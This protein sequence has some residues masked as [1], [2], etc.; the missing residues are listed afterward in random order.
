MVAEF[1]HLHVHSEYS[2]LDGAG[3]IKDLVKRACEL[4]MPAIALTDHGVMY[5]IVEFYEA[6]TEAGIKPIL[7]AEIYYT[8]KSRFDR[9]SRQHAEAHHLLLLCENEVGYH[10][11]IKIVSKAHLEGFYYKPRADKELLAEYHKGL[12]AAS[13]C[14]ASPIC[15][16][17]LRDDIAAAE[18][19]ACEFREIFGPDNF[20]LELQDHG[21]PEQKKV[22]EALIAMSKK[23]GIPLIVTNDIHYVRAEDW[24]AQDVLLAINTGAKSVEEEDRFRF[25]SHEFYLKSADEMKAIFPD[26][27]DALRR[28]VEIAERCN[29]QLQLGEPKMPHYEVPGGLTPEEFLRK[30]CYERLPLR[31]P[32]ASDEVK[33]RLEY[34]LEVICQKG[35]A[36]YFLIVWDIVHYAKSQGILVG[37]GRGSAAGCMVSYILG[38]TNIDPLKYGL[39]FERFL[40]PERQSSPDIDLD[41]PDNRRDE[42]IAYVRRKY[43]ED[44]VA[45]IVTFGTLQAR[46]AVRD[47]GRVLKIDPALVDR[48]AKLIPM[49][50]SLEEALEYSLE[51]R[52]L[53][54][55]D[56]QVRRW[57]D[58][59][60]AIEGLAR[61]AS[62]HPCGVVIGSKPLIELVPLQRGHDGGII[63]QYDGPSAEKVGLVKMDFLGLRNSTIIGRTVELVKETDG[64][65]IDLN[66]L[67]LDDPKTYAMLSEGH[68]VGVFQ[69]EKSG[70][71][72]LLRDLRPDKFE[73]LV[74]LV[75]L[76]RPGPMEDIPKFVDGRHGKPIEYLHP[77][78][79]PILKETFGVML[80]QEQVMRIAHE[81]AGF[82]MPQAEIL[83]RAMAKKKA[84]LMEKMKPLFI[85]GC[86]R[87]GISE[88]DAKRIFERMEAFANYAFN[89]CV[90]A[91]TE[92]VD[93]DTG[94]VV[95]VGELYRQQRSIGVVTLGDNWQ[96]KRGQVVAVFSNGVRPVYE[97]VTQ[98]NRRIKATTNH[99]FL[100]PEGWKF[101][102]EL[103]P[104]DLVAI[105]RRI[106][107]RPSLQWC[108]HHLVVLGYLLSD[109]NLCHPTSVYFY[110][111]EPEVRD[112]FVRALERF[113]NTQARCSFIA[114]Q[115]KWEVYAKRLNRNQL[116]GVVEW[117]TQL[118]I[119]GHKATEKRLPK[120]VFRLP[121]EQI[122]LLLAKMWVGDGC[123]VPKQWIA[124]YSTSS[125]QLAR[126]VQHLLL[127]LGIVATVY[128]KRFRY[129]DEFRKGWAVYI[130]GIENLTKF[131]QILGRYFVGNILKATKELLAKIQ[132]ARGGG[133]T[134][135]EVPYHAVVPLMKASAMQAGLTLKQV[136]EK[137][138]INVRTLHYSSKKKWWRRDT[139]A[140]IAEALN[141]E[142][143]SVWGNSDLFW[144]KVVSVRF[145]GMEEVFDLTV[146]E[147]HNFVA[148]DF[149]VHNSHSAAYALVAYQTAYLKAN[150]PVQ[151]MA[152]FLSANRAFREKVI[153]GIEEC[154]RMKIPIL[155]PDI[156]LSS[157][158]FTIEEHNGQRAIRFGLGAIKNVGDNAV[159]AILQARKQGGPFKDI[160][161][162]LRRVRPYRTVTR[163]VVES[164]IKVGAFDSLHPNRNQL[165]QALETLWEQAGKSAQPAVGQVTLFGSEETVESTATL[166]L[167]DVP[168]VSFREKLEWE[169]ELLGVFL[170]ANPLQ[171]GYQVIASRITHGLDELPEITP[172][173]FVRVW[174]MVVHLKPTVDR[175]NRPL[176]FAK[177]QDH[178]GTEAELVLSGE[179]YHAFAHLFERDALVYVEGTVRVDEVYRHNGN[180]REYDEEDEEPQFVVRIVPRLVERFNLD[181]I[182]KVSRP[183][184][185]VGQMSSQLQPP[186]RHSSE[187]LNKLTQSNAVVITDQVKPTKL[188]LLLPSRL[189]ETVAQRLKELLSTHPGD[190]IVEVVIQ[191]G[192]TVKTRQLS[193]K[194]KLS[195]EFYQQLISLLGRNA[196]RVVR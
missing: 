61:H 16:A 17:I 11:L 73:H 154:R 96:L 70:W 89:K 53:Y 14:L 180:G 153:V 193:T 76:Y 4:E 185:G 131:C 116:S 174:G 179:S 86:V 106:P 24:Q 69:M 129:R 137:S 147:T 38:I 46:A 110:T 102:G 77:R 122:A 188:Q 146:D 78:L 6:C 84:D 168:D 88:E 20:F 149:I 166:L 13:A 60:K 26:Q 5:G 135:G 95:T 68:T 123:V 120:D 32:D 7:G 59:A 178:T 28:T 142:R 25:K 23:L 9:G 66:N 112:D 186:V 75:A 143:L 192:T 152:A 163:A 51:L 35:Y 167:P 63:T 98:T 43:G 67:P 111:T 81:L 196:V 101:L 83:M 170:S 54:E 109:G 74:P 139:V 128:E 12:I 92:L 164:L 55:T 34:E 194:V 124:Y 30:L 158:D 113:P 144:D 117:L 130:T 36:G 107:Y 169:R 85:E 87:N 3:R 119:L 91:D 8:T 45:Q 50:M 172:G 195:R 160:A 49:K 64:I 176:L 93:Y 29:C 132:F 115:G 114:S 171:A 136:A 125:E 165:L 27:I 181:D 100:T 31:Y 47:S 94:E 2:L 141:D 184:N 97:I 104:N 41:F 44:H 133:C 21:I 182:P 151:Y 19:L 103:K 145:V 150:Y 190:T 80:Y 33:R 121:P 57:L 187:R 52:Q 161:D 15:R 90:P 62:T 159:E 105:A 79:E 1:V 99:P 148:N 156:N 18:K 127:R 108:E 48:I 157:Y 162:F 177:I 173:A 58:T 72:K 191:N 140:A 175:Q 22:N 155:P 82:T 37:P 183:T 40:N 118:G 56:E 10:N 39:M 71:R 189:P 65:E 134:K 126:Q 138:G 42:I